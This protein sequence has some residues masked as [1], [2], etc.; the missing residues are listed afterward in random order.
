MDTATVLGVAV[1]LA[2]GGLTWLTASVYTKG[3]SMASIPRVPRRPGILALILGNLQDLANFRY[4]RTGFSW[5]QQCGEIARLRVL[6]TQVSLQFTA[7]WPSF[8]LLPAATC[9][10][11]DSDGCGPSHSH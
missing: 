7:L 6:W 11:A 3:Q 2:L 10:Y 1:A 4:H 8:C 9:S 5:T